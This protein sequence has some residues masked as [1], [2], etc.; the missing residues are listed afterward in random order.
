MKSRSDL[1]RLVAYNLDVLDQALA[2]ITAHESAPGADFSRHCGPHLRHVIEHYQA[3]LDHVHERSID[4]DD[5][6]RDA[7]AQRC[8]ATA[9]ARLLDIRQRLAAL[10]VEALPDRLAIHLR[11]GCAGDD[12]FVT[13]SSVGREL[14]FV[15]SHAVHHY[16]IIQLHCRRHGIELG[17]DFG[18]APSTL[19]HERRR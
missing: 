8:T 5:R 4:Y 6:P 15:A 2:V 11:G 19:R 17:A 14:M 18:K 3:F 13:F 10:R 1:D 12:N 7:Q 16:A 9:R